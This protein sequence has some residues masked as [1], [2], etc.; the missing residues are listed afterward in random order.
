MAPES[1]RLALPLS[2]DPV[3]PGDE[4]GSGVP[5]APEAPETPVAPVAPAAPV[6]P[7]ATDD[8]VAGDTFPV[9]DASGGGPSD[10]TSFPRHAT[11]RTNAADTATR[12][13][14]TLA[15]FG[16]L[17]VTQRPVRPVSASGVVA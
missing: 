9:G 1:E 2:T 14:R 7:V 8:G 11:S 6:A 10:S 13:E 16:R 3:K 15:P 4:V 12:L 5:V 17:T